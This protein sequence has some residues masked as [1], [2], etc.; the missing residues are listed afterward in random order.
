MNVA[1]SNNNRKNENNNNNNNNNHNNVNDKT[2]VQLNSFQNMVTAMGQSPGRRR[3]R[4][5]N[6]DPTAITPEVDMI[7]V[8]MS[9]YIYSPKKFLTISQKR[10]QFCRDICIVRTVFYTYT[11][12]YRIYP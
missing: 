9:R 2:T 5:A 6:D 7:K 3:R 4:L 1:N 8:T 12:E 11:A 10:I